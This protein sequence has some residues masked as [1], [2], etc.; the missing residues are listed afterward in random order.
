MRKYVFWGTYVSIP[1]GALWLGHAQYAVNIC[2][3]DLDGL[4]NVLISQM[5]FACPDRI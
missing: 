2:Q 1:K 4:K 5:A 3:Y